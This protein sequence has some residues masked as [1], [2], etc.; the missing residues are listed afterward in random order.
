[1]RDSRIHAS[2]RRVAE[3]GPR[4]VSLALGAFILSDLGRASWLL[5][6]TDPGMPKPAPA[7]SAPVSSRID[8]QR[9]MAG[10]LFGVAAGDQDPDK[11]PLSTANLQLAGTI[12]TDDPKRGL[13]IIG[14]DGRIKVYNVGDP[15]DGAALFSVYLDHVILR[16]G[17][18]FETLTLP[19]VLARSPSGNPTTPAAATA[20]L[21]DTDASTRTNARSAADAV[22][23]V[24]ATDPT[25]KIRGL[26]VF[27]N[28]DRAAF[29]NSGLHGGDLVVAIN[30]RSLQ[31][32]DRQSGQ[33]I[34]SA[35]K[36]STQATVTVERNGQMQDVT[37]DTVGIGP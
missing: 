29:D 26:R 33:A 10:H 1:M 21:D 18:N 2:L 4:L 20:E 25:G 30:G 34:V 32:Q 28:G 15:V 13:A 24:M 8:V 19:R 31:G 5:V 9:I 37:I 35:L 17:G 27:P 12:A 23:G 36:T 22:R 3:N 16:R 6:R 7:R 11:A 14:G